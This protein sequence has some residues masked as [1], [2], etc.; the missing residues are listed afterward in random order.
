MKKI[1]LRVGDI[2]SRFS[3][4]EEEYVLGIVVEVCTRNSY[5]LALIKFF[6]DLDLCYDAAQELKTNGSFKNYQYAS[7]PIK[8]IARGTA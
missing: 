3:H 8:L 7:K 5:P 2:I 6:D 4:L 1:E